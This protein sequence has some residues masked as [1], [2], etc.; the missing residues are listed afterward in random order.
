MLNKRTIFDEF[1]IRGV[2]FKNRIGMAPMCQYSAENGFPNDFHL[3][4]YGSKSYGT[5]LIIVEATAV[6]DIGRISPGDLGIYLDE[7]VEAHKR[8]IN[9]VHKNSNA[10][11]GIQLAHAGRKASTGEPFHSVY[12]NRILTEENR[13][14]K[15]LVAPSSIP[16]RDDGLTPNELTVE[17]I[18]QQIDEYWTNAVKRSIKAG[19][20]FIEIHGAH[21]YLIH[22]FLSPI[23]N[24]RTDIYGG[25]FENRTRFLLEIVEKV[26]S[27]WNGPL[28]VRLSADDNFEGGWTI[29]DSIKLVEVLKNSGVDLIDVSSGGINS[30]SGRTFGPL[31]QIDLSEKIKKAVSGILVA[32]VGGITTPE[33]IKTVIE[34]EKADVTLIGREFLRNSEF[35]LNVHKHF[36]Q[37]VDYPK[38]YGYAVDPVGHR[39]QKKL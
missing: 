15:N 4:H 29:D 7:H 33:E 12:P 1:E 9:F 16:F 38:Q 22:S 32:S 31:Y 35:S 19:Y 8:I 36:K 13:G 37:F 39:T 23:S 18:K 17:E 30:R 25:S 34:E 2:T 14:W 24:K 26:R 28:F 5:G 21:G 10:K 3:M 20:D 11:I 27:L 6:Q